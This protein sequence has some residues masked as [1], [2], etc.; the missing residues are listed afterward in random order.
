M[1]QHHYYVYILHKPSG[2]LY[3]GITNDIERRM[4]EHK[5]KLIR[6]FT[7]KYN[8]TRLVYD[9]LYGEPR[10]A[11]AREKEIKGWLRRKKLAL[12]RSTNPKFHDISEDWSI[13][14]SPRA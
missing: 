13:P 14:P 3:T 2:V 10:A 5:H 12:I 9:E 11:I 6:G 4:C 7:Q 1:R 8:V